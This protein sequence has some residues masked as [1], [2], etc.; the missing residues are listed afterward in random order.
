M[1]N[2]GPIS[3]A[4]EAVETASEMER[5]NGCNASAE[6]AEELNASTSTKRKLSV[7]EKA[8][9]IT[10]TSADETQNTKQAKT[11]AEQTLED[12]PVFDDGDKL[13][14]LISKGKN[15]MYGWADGIMSLFSR[16]EIGAHYWAKHMIYAA[17][18]VILKN[19]DDPDWEGDPVPYVSIKGVG[20]IKDLVAAEVQFEDWKNPDK[21]K[22]EGD[23][24]WWELNLTRQEPLETTKKLKVKLESS[25]W[26]NEGYIWGGK[27]LGEWWL[28]DIVPAQGDSLKALKMV[29]ARIYGDGSDGED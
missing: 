20:S 8:E 12:K 26:D 1:S 18:D 4:K 22:H 19:L 28:T 25:E 27:K 17:R 7:G 2:I 24:W 9:I 13:V 11:E 16:E 29:H 5:E 3:T 14:P 10:S 23:G 6:S 15:V 21:S